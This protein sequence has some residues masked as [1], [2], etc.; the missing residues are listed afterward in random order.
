[1]ENMSSVTL[2][3]LFTECCEDCKEGNNQ[4]QFIPFSLLHLA[5]KRV[6]LNS[7]QCEYDVIKDTALK[8][9]IEKV[10]F[11]EKKH[12]IHSRATIKTGTE[13]IESKALKNSHSIIK[14]YCECR[15]PMCYECFWYKNKQN[16]KSHSHF[17][18][19]K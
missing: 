10:K 16:I 19:N 6:I 8:F 14:L 1:M 2:Y 3:E 7:K 5:T 9:Q 18:T 17:C 13:L 11:S 15:F 12:S 4:K